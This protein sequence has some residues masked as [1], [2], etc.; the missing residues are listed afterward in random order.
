MRTSDPV[1]QY[2]CSSTLRLWLYYCWIISNI[3][4]NNKDYRQRQDSCSLDDAPVSPEHTTMLLFR[5]NMMNKTRNVCIR[6]IEA[7][8]RNYC[9]QNKYYIFWVCV[10]SSNARAPYFHLWPVRLYNI[11][12]H[13]LINLT[14]ISKR[15]KRVSEQEKCSDFLYKSCLKTFR[16]KKNWARYVLKCVW[17]FV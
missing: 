5:N 8:S 14:S 3:N 11:F 17:V 4:S 15:K 12:P 2:W 10:C 16:S 7:L 6:N 1:Q 13:Y 9:C